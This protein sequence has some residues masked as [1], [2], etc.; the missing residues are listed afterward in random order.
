M[1]LAHKLKDQKPPVIHDHKFEDQKHFMPP[2]RDDVPDFVD[3]Q[4]NSPPKS[5]YCCYK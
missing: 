4:S 3:L 2:V 5:S 1:T